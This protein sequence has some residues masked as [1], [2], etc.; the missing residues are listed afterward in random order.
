MKSENLED[1]YELSPLQQGLLFHTIYA[2]ESGVYFEQFSWTLQGNLDVSAFK[3]AWQQVIE[4]HAILRT[5]FYW[6]EL[7]KPYQ[8]VYSQVPLPWKYEDW[9]GISEIEQKQ[10]IEAFLQLDRQQGFDLT[11]APL[12]R[13]SLFKLAAETYQFVW[14]SHHLLLDGWSESLVFKEVY[15]Y[16]QDKE[17][18]LQRSRPYRDY[19]I[20]LQQQDL[21]QAETFWRKQLEGFTQPTI[22]K[23]D[24]A[25]SSLPSQGEDYDWQRIELSKA[26]RASLQ[27]WGRQN[28]LTMNTLVQGAWA[29]LLSRYSGESDILFGSTSSGRPAELKGVESMVGLFVNTLP[30]RV[31]V[32]PHASLIPWLQQLQATQIEVLEYEYSPL[33]RV[34]GWSKVERGLPL[35]EIGYVLENYPVDFALSEGEDGIKLTNSQSF[36]KTNEA[37]SLLA[38]PEES[39]RLELWYDTRRFDSRAIA[40]MLVHLQTLLENMAESSDI[41]LSELS[42]LT[43][44]EKEL[45]LNEWGQ[46]ELSISLSPQSILDLF[47]RRVQET[48][49]AIALVWESEKLTYAQLDR[50]INLLATALIDTGVKTGDL[51]AIYLERSLEIAIAP[52]AVLKAGGTYLPLDPAYPPQ[53]LAFMLEDAKAT[54][55]LT[56]ESLISQLPN[57]SARVICL[58][59][60]KH[61]SPL[62]P[63]RAQSI[64]PLQPLTPNPLAYIIYTSG[65]TG[66]PKGV[67]VSHSSLVNAYLAWE[68][69]YQ[70]ENTTCHLQMASF[71]F[72]VFAGDL[73]RAL[74]SGKKLVLCPR[75]F[76]L[77]PQK[78]YALMVRERVDCAEF[79]PAVLR[80]LMQYLEETQQRLDLMRSLICGSDLWY[81]EEY[82]RYSHLCGSNTQ[83][84]NSFGVTEATIDS[85]YFSSEIRSPQNPKSKMALVPIGRPFANVELYILDSDLQPVPIG[86]PGELYIGGAGLAWGYHQQP[87]LTA[88]KFIPH[89]YS[90]RA[91]DRLYQTGDSACWLTDGNIEFLGRLD[92]QE[93]IRGYRL[94][95]GEIEATLAQYPGVKQVAAVTQLDASGEKRLVAYVAGKL[96]GENVAKLETEQIS[97]WQVVYDSEAEIFE[98]ITSKEDFTFN[99]VGWNSSYTGAAIPA[100]EMREW[101]NN[102]VE[103]ILALKPDKILEIGCGT[104]LLLFPIAPHCTEYRGT[105]FSKTA[106]GYIEKV[107]K[108]PEY[109]LPQA[110]LTQRMAD[111]FEGLEPESYDTV[112]INSVIQYFPSL[113][114]L[115]RVLQ[116][117]LQVL[118]PGGKLFIGD[119]RSLPLLEAFHTSIVLHQAED[120]LSVTALQ[121]QV[122][123]R[124]QQEEELVID[125]AL[126]EALVQHFPQIENVEI[127]P[128]QGEFEN[129]LTKFRYD[130]VLVKAQSITPLQEVETF[131]HLGAYSNNPLQT[132]LNRESIPKLR[133][134]LQQRLPEYMVPSHFVLLETLP[135]T[136]NGKLDRKALPSLDLERSQLPSSS[137]TPQNPIQEMLLGIWTQV[138]GVE[139]MGIEDNFFELGGHSLLATQVISRVREVFQVEI[140]LRSLF[141]TPTIQAL[142]E[143]IQS[144]MQLSSVLTIPPLVKAGRERELPLSF[145][146]QRLWLASQLTPDSSI[147]NDPIAV[148][149]QGKLNIPAL[150][151]SIN[152][153]IRRHEVL[154]TSFITIKGQP[155][156]S[157]A[158]HLTI[159]LPVTDLREIPVAERNAIAQDLLIQQAREPFDLQ[160]APLIRTSLIWLDE[161]EYLLTFI[162]HHIASDGWSMGVLLAE[163]TEIYPAFHADLPSPLPELPIQYADFAIW[164]RQWFQG[165]ILDKQLDYWRKQLANLPSLQLPTDYPLVT[166]TSQGATIPFTLSS[167]LTQALQKLSQQEGVTLFM[168]LLAAFQTLLYCYSKQ[169]DFGIG[170]PIANRNR[171]EIEKLIGFFINTLVLRADL[172]NN[173]TFRELLARVREVTLGAYTHQDLPFEKIVEELRPERQRDRV[174]LYQAWFV[175]H[176]TPLGSLELSGLSLEPLEVHSGSTDLDL[177][178]FLEEVSEGLS[179]CFEYNTSLFSR[180]TV[181]QIVNNFESLIERAI[182]DPDLDLS[183]LKEMIEQAN[184]EQ[185]TVQESELKAANIR[186]LQN[187]K[188]QSLV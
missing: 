87:D 80:N 75:D 169:T 181:G 133:E 74:C 82:N 57:T 144:Q 79:V 15:A 187:I 176:N 49:D 109:H 62:T 34:Q 70:L 51:V 50:E 47:T 29:L 159:P 9:Q 175:L 179:G 39:L 186:L 146:Q 173:P 14:S 1:I 121:Q 177:G 26:A 19:I 104:G 64:A 20:W 45:L 37:L 35:F 31:Q 33:V 25:P 72:D 185:K 130:A 129:E 158:P 76:L 83:I 73:I 142:A 43:S 30:L 152:E 174:P 60:L 38:V 161:T 42:M 163:I 63:V 32:P 18:Q 150:E 168:T 61:P 13:L 98:Q 128:K 65:S 148:K 24:R 114:Y 5:A 3:R 90:K 85:S 36:E 149:I 93:K 100:K 58:S 167:D 134:Y 59:E 155:V 180:Q 41:R 11:Q 115:M 117:A 132:K 103:R 53:R 54:L 106:L 16:Y 4:R 182:A 139:G 172:S 118:K 171:T 44:E 77:E 102:T 157:I 12:I 131:P 66:K 140:P 124:M 111:N 92:T 8:V 154:R 105:D 184:R 164:Q 119:V 122:Q 138:L 110:T 136:P 97:Q 123:K 67:M 17:S 166:R 107:L 135:L 78:L 81:M 68:T 10:K 56:Q 95:L 2:P 71:A 151:K 112:V 88:A 48:P 113:A 125:P 46:N 108:M 86:V 160:A 89:P 141:E 116:G 22:L 55:V 27:A 84:I 170:S 7:E 162:L 145:A 147:Y 126:F 69:A 120:S 94:E 137:T 6:Q 21:N 96:A 52:L 178:L 188:R 101:V 28:Q 165:E 153:I 183:A 127:L 156:Q 91:G 99:I 143:E 40:Q 23:C